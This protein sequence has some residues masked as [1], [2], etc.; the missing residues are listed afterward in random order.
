MI[1]AGTKADLVRKKPSLRQ[2]KVEEILR[3]AEKYGAA[4]FETSAKEN[5]NVSELFDCI[6]HQFFT[7]KTAKTD[8]DME[9]VKSYNEE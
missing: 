2:V 4:H 1:I 8:N 3:L 9:A 6:G 5:T 7:L